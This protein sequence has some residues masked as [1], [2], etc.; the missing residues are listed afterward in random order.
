MKQVL[1]NRT[2]LA[3]VVGCMCIIGKLQTIAAQMS[4]IMCTTNYPSTQIGTTIT[5]IVSMGLAGGV[6]FVGVVKKL[7]R[8]VDALK[9][10]YSIASIAMISLLLCLRK[11]HLYPLILVFG[12]I[13][14]FFGLSCFPLSMELAVEEAFPLD[15]VFT[16]VTT[17][18]PGQVYGFLLILLSNSLNWEVEGA[19]SHQ[20]GEDIQ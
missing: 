5:V 18:L 4:Q 1:S 3:M 15:P 11:P 6:L 7:G 13:F 10:S 12:A 9:I 17:H 20:C 16:E 8:Q 14:G 19:S 2:I